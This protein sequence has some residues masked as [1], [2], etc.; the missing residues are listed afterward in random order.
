MVLLM[1]AAADVPHRGDGTPATMTTAEAMA[2][3]RPTAD[4]RIAYGPDPL[5]F[6]EL[7][8]PAGAGPHPVAIV[9]HGGCWLAEYDL[10]YISGLAAALA[11]S[12]IATWSLEYRRVG[13]DG[14]GWPGTFLDV[15]RGADHLRSLADDFGLD[16]G[17]VVAVGHSAGG[18]LALWLAARPRLGPGDELRGPDPLPIHGVVA[19]AGIADL[20]AYASPDGCGAAVAPLLGGPPDEVPDRVRRVSPVELVP[21]GVPQRLVVGALDPFVPPDH[22]RGY[23]EAAAAAGD[24]VRVTVVPG[25]GHFEPTA[26]EREAFATV[27][28]AVLSAVDRPRPAETQKERPR[29]EGSP[30][31]E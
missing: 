16:L 8:L 6:G 10:G 3:P 23:A 25:A 1:T 22:V 28:E 11:D 5:Q 13:D 18:H 4:H 30:G 26:P 14:G 12:G 27:R 19:I 7:R 24:A 15:G 31:R 21:L 17:R 20:A 9:L 29:G 2:M